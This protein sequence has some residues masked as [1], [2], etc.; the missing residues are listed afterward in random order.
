[1]VKSETHRDPCLKIRA[2]DST[3]RKPSPRLNF[4]KIRAGFETVRRT[5]RYS[6]INKYVWIYEK[7]NGAKGLISRTKRAFF[8][9]QTL[10]P[11]GTI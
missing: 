9:R 11:K 4:S 1:M 2:R 6:K 3:R 7:K 5:T 8:P 10:S